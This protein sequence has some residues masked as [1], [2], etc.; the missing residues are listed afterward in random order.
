MPLRLRDSLSGATRILAPRPRRPITLYV[1]GPTVYDVAHVG[2][3]RTL[4]FFDLIRRYLREERSPVQHVLNITDFEDKLDARAT[5]LHLTWRTLARREERSFLRDM[6]TFGL[7]PATAT[8][9][10]STFVPQMIRLGR[11]LARVGRVEHRDDE[12]IFTPPRSFAE[13]NF[14]I[15]RDLARHAVLEPGVPPPGEPAGGGEFLLWKQ[16]RRPHP[17]WPSPWGAGVPGWHMECYA[18]AEHYLGIPVDLHGGGTDLIYPHHYDENEI[19]FSIAGQPFSR[20]F[21]H[22][23]LVRQNGEKMSKSTGN[24]VPLRAALEEMGPGALRWY[25]LKSPYHQAFDWNTGDVVRARQE[26]ATVVRRC[27]S[28]VEP[29]AG[30]SLSLAELE[31]VVR[32]VRRFFENGLEVHRAVDRLKEW[33]TAIE[34]A[35][36]ARFGRG[37]IRRARAHYETLERLLGFPLISS[38]GG[39]RSR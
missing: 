30:G 3:A 26:Y 23:G 6:S 18:M 16:Q 22:A 7:L 35:G 34:R 9:R 2:H 14:P 32:D 17:S 24:L 21:L 13:K 4:L 29:G 31:R 10:A 5:S 33:N 37:E 20:I 1:C 39:P 19:A 25:L 11:R 8:P 27:R 36:F 15:G 38:A 12:W 28:S